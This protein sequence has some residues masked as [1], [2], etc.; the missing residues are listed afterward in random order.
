[1][2]V[3]ESTKYLI[4]QGPV[5][6]YDP[7][8][9]G[10]ARRNQQEEKSLR[11]WEAHRAEKV[12]VAGLN[13]PIQILE[14][15]SGLSQTVGT[16]VQQ[17]KQ[18]DRKKDAEAKEYVK[19]LLDR[20]PLI[21]EKIAEAWRTNKDLVFSEDNDVY[22]KLKTDLDANSN[23]EYKSLWSELENISA[24][25]QINLKEEVAIREGHRL[26]HS[27]AYRNSEEWTL[28][29]AAEK[30]AYI[31]DSPT[32]KLQT[33]KDW[34]HKKIA[35][36]GISDEL[37]I[38]YMG[39]ELS[40]STATQK[41]ISN[42]KASYS[43]SQKNKA[44][45]GQMFK[46]KAKTLDS[47]DVLEE[48]KHQTI[49]VAEG[50]TTL[51]DGTTPLQQAAEIVLE[52]FSHLN[53]NG[54]I[55]QLSITD[56]RNYT[57]DH[58][59]GKGGKLN[60][61]D[62]FFKGNEE[63][64]HSIIQDNRIGQ[65]AYLSTQAALDK[66]YVTQLLTDARTPGK[67]TRD[68]LD[69]AILNLEGR[70]FT[71]QETLNKLKKLDVDK[72]DAASYQK[73]KDSHWTRAEAIGDIDSE[74]NV[75]LAKTIENNKLANE[76]T[77]MQRDLKISKNKNKFKSYDERTT[78]NN[79][80]VLKRAGTRTVGDNEISGFE[81]LLSNE[82]TQLESQLYID[83]W[84]RDKTATNISEQVAIER[85]R[86][87]TE[88]GFY[89][90]PGTAEEGIWTRDSNGNFTNYQN[91]VTARNSG[92]KNWDISDAKSTSTKTDINNWDKILTKS[93]VN[94]RTTLGIGYVNPSQLKNE[95]VKAAGVVYQS[96]TAAM[97]IANTPGLLEPDDL[98]ASWPADTGPNK[99]LNVENFKITPKVAY[100]ASKLPNVSG[101]DLWRIQTQ[102]L[103]NSK[104][105][106][107]Q[108][109]VEL[110]GLK[111]KLANLPNHHETLKAVADRTGDKYINSIV[112]NG[113]PSNFTPNQ[114]QRLL[115]SRS[116]VL[117]ENYAETETKAEDNS[118]LQLQIDELKKAGK[119]PA[120][121]EAWL[122]SL[123]TTK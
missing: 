48:F 118:R 68:D 101:T 91:A 105:P 31:D 99:Q 88:N 46:T 41:G 111:D 37:V 85:K 47:F 120:E 39:A 74:D 115:N 86:I 40:R 13:T 95:N 53:R 113:D 52:R 106:K 28:L 7:L 78:A 122:R 44:L 82:I 108:Q 5:N 89:A 90:E 123:N 110:F 54:F 112:T 29:S 87:L 27:E 59:A 12:R 71:S 20:Y 75:A 77:T 25:R 84:K 56:L 73:E 66:D 94:A 109:I 8:A 79:S 34:V 49:Q 57:F 50:L 121:I 72:Q 18:S 36:M 92:I 55:P 33:R 4:G 23:Q 35:E 51:E 19:N 38:K 14:K 26:S 93:R 65:Q 62:A 116:P 80:L 43:Y 24:R 83:I 69:L 119:T 58:P 1:M 42:A 61:L 9:E 76:V 16:L 107:D 60:L 6:W 97:R 81:E 114:L 96:N 3:P 11:E 17:K 63:V 104:D 45:Y 64:F 117:P 22:K 67:M 98:V 15:L 103:I 70:G 21:G 32:G 10:V 100:L 102:L 30:K 2:A